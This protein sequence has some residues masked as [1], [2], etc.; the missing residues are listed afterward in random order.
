MIAFFS[1]IFLFFFSL[2]VNVFFL[3]ILTM[4]FIMLEL[5]FSHFEECVFP[6]GNGQVLH[7]RKKGKNQ[8]S[9]IRWWAAEFY[10]HQSNTC[11]FFQFF[12]FLLLLTPLVA[13]LT[14][15]STMWAYILSSCMSVCECAMQVNNSTIQYVVLQ[16]MYIMSLWTRKT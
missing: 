14:R 1:S 12:F 5:K 4:L 11:W 16:W 9:S 8:E 13:Q 3:V 2:N 6:S 15:N 7:K 10:P